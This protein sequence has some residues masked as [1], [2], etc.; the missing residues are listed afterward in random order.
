MPF[1]PAAAD[2]V[3]ENRCTFRVVSAASYRYDRPAHQITTLLRLVPP[4]ERGL[5]RLRSHEV[6][7]A[8]LPYALPEYQDEW[9]N[10]VIEARN[11][12]V[13]EHLTVIVELTA[14]TACRYDAEGRSLPTPIPASEPAEAERFLAFTRRTTPSPDLEQFAREL[15]RHHDPSV[16][17]FGFAECLRARV[18]SEMTFMSGATHVGTTAGEAWEG[19]RGVCQDY[20][21]ITL[22]LCRLAG[23]PARY[24]SGFVPGEGVM[25]AWVEALLPGETMSSAWFALDPTYDKWVNERYVAVAVGRDYA[26]ATPTS[27]S[28]YGGS[29]SLRYSTR[30]QTVRRDLVL[31]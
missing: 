20:T 19:R 22:T 24:V 12:A 26:D 14:D 31:L 11:E 10:R 17:P 5:Q 28:Y 25:H 30:M 16:D 8:P 18:H 1:A 7:I 2:A 27:G 29:S 13:N 9:G 4:D 3:A 21:H 15:R 6:Q 23:V